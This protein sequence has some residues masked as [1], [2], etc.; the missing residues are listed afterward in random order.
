MK[1]TPVHKLYR[2]FVKTIKIARIV[3]VMYSELQLSS[4]SFK[5]REGVHEHYIRN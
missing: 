1:C 5:P 2:Y 3:A 4:R